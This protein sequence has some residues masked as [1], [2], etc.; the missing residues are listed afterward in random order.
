MNRVFNPLSG[1][2]LPAS[3][4]LLLACSAQA[5]PVTVPGTYP[6]TTPGETRTAPPTSPGRT[7]RGTKLARAD[8]KFLRQAAQNG[9]AELELSQLALAKS[10]SQEVK[11]FA[12][13]LLQDHSRVNAD[14]KS[15]AEARD[16]RVP[17]QPSLLQQPTLAVLAGK[18]GEEFDRGY[19]ETMGVKAH[20]ATVKLFRDAAREAKD[21]EIKAFAAKYVPSLE[22][23]L[24]MARQ[25]HASLKSSSENNG[26]DALGGGI[27]PGGTTG[28]TARTGSGA[29]QD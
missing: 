18:D 19:I 16:L 11:N 21:P 22:Q 9:Y 20:E 12:Q 6:A 28:G 7:V 5:Q 3:L 2:C 1:L 26:R 17:T 24:E 27:G 23:H 25:I 15:L 4:A 10:T 29:S 13:R 8:A 14:L